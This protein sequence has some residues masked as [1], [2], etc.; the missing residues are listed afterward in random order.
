V[1]AILRDAMRPAG[2]LGLGSALAAIGAKYGGVDIELMR[3]DSPMRIADL[4]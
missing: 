4:P 2:A 1:R 3:C